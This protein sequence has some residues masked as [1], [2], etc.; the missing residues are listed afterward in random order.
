MILNEMSTICYGGNK[1]CENEVSNGARS[2][3]THTPQVLKTPARNALYLPNKELALVLASEWDSQISK[4][5]IQPSLMPVMTL[6]SSAIDQ[7]EPDVSQTI[8][9]LLPYL[10]TDTICFP[11]DD[12]DHAELRRRQQEMWRPLHLKLNELGIYLGMSDR[13]LSI[14]CH[15]PD[16]AL[17]AD[18]LLRTFSSLELSAVQ[19]ITMECKSLAIGIGLAMRWIS[20][21][22]VSY[23]DSAVINLWS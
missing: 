12:P 18:S 6:V 1:K 14:P 13:G 5:G 20:V 15:S 3:P 2:V 21:E 11:C 9:T 22:E 17:Q 7:I 23:R 16:A 19:A 10:E 8:D 4:G